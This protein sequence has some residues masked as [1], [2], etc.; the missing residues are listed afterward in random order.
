MSRRRAQDG[1]LITF[2]G[3]EGSGKSTHSRRLGAWLKRQGYPVLLTREPGGTGMGRR[4]RKILLHHRR[5]KLDPLTELCLYE[6][7]R[8][9]LVRQVIRPALKQGSVVIADRFQDSTWVY[10]G[11]AG[12]VPIELVEQ[13][14]R[15]TTDGL[16]PDLTLLLDLPVRQGLSRVKHPNRM[17]AKPVGFHEK[18]RQGYL[19][20]Y[21]R[22]KRRFCL[23]RADE[24][25]SQVQQAIRKAVKNVLCSDP[26]V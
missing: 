10:Q 1:F 14:G 12:G 23:I 16:T 24:A 3:P 15:L 25:F 19:T 5:E 7:S 18:V 4:L 2:E 6:A 20:L 26:R 11:W 8:A 9:M 13:L 17:E 21:R 22:Q